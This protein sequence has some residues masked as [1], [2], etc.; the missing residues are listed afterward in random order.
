MHWLLRQ[1]TLLGENKEPLQKFKAL[2]LGRL[3][4]NNVQSYWVVVLTEEMNIWALQ[5][6]VVDES[7]CNDIDDDEDPRLA[8]E[9]GYISTWYE[10]IDN[11]YGGAVAVELGTLDELKEAVEQGTSFL[12]ERCLSPQ[13]VSGWIS[14]LVPE[15]AQGIRFVVDIHLL[16]FSWH[17]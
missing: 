3:I 2:T 6:G 12:S 15:P 11:L 16:S 10:K 4:V 9:E 17:F 14:A 8:P 13:G 1:V 5:A 7:E